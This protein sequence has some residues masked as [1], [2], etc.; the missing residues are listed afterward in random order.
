MRENI[1]GSSGTAIPQIQVLWY[2][3]RTY[4][5]PPWNTVPRYRHSSLHKDCVGIAVLASQGLCGRG[6]TKADLGRGAH[7]GSNCTEEEAE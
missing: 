4:E 7:G 6:P 5:N 3:Q 1:G 2:M